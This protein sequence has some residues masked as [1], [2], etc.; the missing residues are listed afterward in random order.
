MTTTY[1]LSDLLNIDSSNLS[2]EY[3]TQAARYG[4]FATELAKLDR[5]VKQLELERDAEYAN[6]DLEYRKQLT[7]Q[8]TKYTETTIRSMVL[9]DD[10]YC[11]AEE[12]LRDSIQERDSIKALVKALEMRAEMLISLGAMMRQ[13]Y[14]MT[15]MTIKDEVQDN[16]S[17]LKE[18]ARARG[19]K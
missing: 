19:T 4:F 6:A 13:E 15:G 12:S 7:I 1:N 2:Q 14:Q 16:I 5:R 11:K 18:Q 3:A 8:G 10:G 9:T 17:K